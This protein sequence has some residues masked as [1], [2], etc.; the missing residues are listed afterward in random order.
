MIERLIGR[1]LHYGWLIVIVTFVTLMCILAAGLS[2][3]IGARER[4][5][6]AIAAPVTA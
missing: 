5:A 6:V 3:R 2:L 4:T 1:P